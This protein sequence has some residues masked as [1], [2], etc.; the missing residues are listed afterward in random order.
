[1]FT[2][3]LSVSIQLPLYLSPEYK[4]QDFFVGK[5]DFFTVISALKAVSGMV[6]AINI[7]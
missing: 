5:N 3:F 7:Y 2:C 4:F 6:C 1:M